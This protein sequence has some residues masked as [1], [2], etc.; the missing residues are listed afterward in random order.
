MIVN[1][2]I[3]VTVAITF[4]QRDKEIALATVY[5]PPGKKVEFETLKHLT[6]KYEH[7]IITGDFNSKHAYFANDKND[8]ADD[9]LFNITEELDLTILCWQQC[10]KHS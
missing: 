8:S 1:N 6:D 7:S 4:K 3:A 2:Y 9:A 10:G 5:N